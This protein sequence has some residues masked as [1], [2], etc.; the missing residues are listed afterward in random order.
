VG[1][2]SIIEE[3]EQSAFKA[4]PDIMYL[5]NVPQGAIVCSPEDLYVCFR[6]VRLEQPFWEDQEIFLHGIEDDE[7][8]DEIV[9]RGVRKANARVRAQYEEEI[10]LG[11]PFLILDIVDGDVLRTYLI[12]KQSVLDAL[13]HNGHDGTDYDPRRDGYAWSKDDKQFL[14]GRQ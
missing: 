2:F 4:L 8:S 7:E 13:K 11:L 6:R 14:D 10:N 12:P 3:R 5:A 1:R 9:P